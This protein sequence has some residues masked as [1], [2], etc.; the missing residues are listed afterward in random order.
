[1]SSNKQEAVYLQRKMVALNKLIPDSA[2]HPNPLKVIN[3]DIVDYTIKTKNTT[4]NIEYIFLLT[5]K[6]WHHIEL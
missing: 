2:L 3:I 4:T 6:N 5:V 1:M